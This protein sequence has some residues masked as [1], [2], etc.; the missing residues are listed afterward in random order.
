MLAGHL[1]FL[2]TLVFFPAK[3]EEQGA[4]ALGMQEDKQQVSPAAG[5]PNPEHGDSRSLGDNINRLTESSK[6]LFEA[7]KQITENLN[8]LTQRVERV[9]VRTSEIAKS[10]WLL[11][12]MAVAAGAL[13]LTLSRRGR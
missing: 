12:G 7:G 2:P 9:S 8:E 3:S 13:I 5:L 6:H 1:E 4:V 10:P 11:A